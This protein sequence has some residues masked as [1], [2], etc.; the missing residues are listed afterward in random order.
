MFP[1]CVH[2]QGNKQTQCV[3]PRN[4]GRPRLR[5]DKAQQPSPEPILFVGASCYLAQRLLGD[6]AALQQPAASNALLQLPAE[7]V[8]AQHGL[9]PNVSGPRVKGLNFG[10]DIWM[11]GNPLVLT[12][13]LDI[14]QLN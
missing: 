9:H 10:V 5:S 7:L 12:G 14:P 6:R 3:S 2:Q 11:A 1:P 8:P 13:D 4:H